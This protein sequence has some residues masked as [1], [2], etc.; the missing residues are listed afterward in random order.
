MTDPSE[1]AKKSTANGDT[2]S[3]LRLRLRIVRRN[4]RS[5]RAM[6]AL[7][8]TFEGVLRNWS[9]SWAPGE[10]NRLRHSAMY[11]VIAT[12]WPRVRDGMARR[13]AAYT[14]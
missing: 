7:G 12:E 11:S 5:R 3:G 6:D 13:I 8:L 9:M 14:T 1:Y 2:R 4:V 10:G